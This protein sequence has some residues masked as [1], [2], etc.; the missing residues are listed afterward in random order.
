M[1]DT[2]I[3]LLLVFNAGFLFG[4]LVAALLNRSGYMLW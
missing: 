2:H 3:A 1:T 4:L